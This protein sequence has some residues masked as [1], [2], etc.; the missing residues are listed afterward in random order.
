MQRELPANFIL[1]KQIPW[2]EIFNKISLLL[3]DDNSIG[4]EALKYNVNV[5]YFALTG[6]VYDGDRL[7]YYEKNK[8]VI[9]SVEQFKQTL[10]NMYQ[11]KQFVHTDYQYNMNYLY[12]YFAPITEERLQRFL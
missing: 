11:N 4:V 2:N 3:Y 8:L 5:G 7:F 1:A 10:E 6:Q 12:Q 9:L